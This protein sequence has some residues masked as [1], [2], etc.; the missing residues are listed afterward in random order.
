M[1]TCTHCNEPLPFRKVAFLSKWRNN[2]QC[3]TCHHILE[4]DENQLGIIGGISGGVG[5]VFGFL[6]VYSFLDQ[7]QRA[8]IFFLFCILAVFTGAIIQYRVIK[9]KPKTSN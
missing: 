6:T 2:V 4:G 7:P 5:G 9:L 1:A 3:P 8:P